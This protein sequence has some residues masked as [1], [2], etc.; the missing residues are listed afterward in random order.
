[1]SRRNTVRVVS[2][3]L[4]VTLSFALFSFKTKLERDNY[5]LQAQNRYS[6]TLNE[7]CASTDSMALLLQ[8]MQYFTSPEK[9]SSA[10]ATLLTQAEI[11][12]NA[13]AQLP[14]GNE[15]DALNKYLSQIGNYAAALAKKAGKTG[16]LTAEEA[17][18]IEYL[19]GVSQAVAQTLNNSRNS[20]DNSEYWYK[21]VQNSLKNQIDTTALEQSF[22]DLQE[23]FKD[24]PTLIYDGPYSEHILTKSPE[25]LANAKAVTKVEAEKTALEW[26]D[27][28]AG[29]LDFAGE[30]AGSIATYDFYGA[31][32]SVSVTQKGGYVLYLSRQFKINEIKIDSGAALKN[33]AEFLRKNNMLNMEKTYY[34]ESDGVCTVNYAYRQGGTLCYTDLVKVGVSME[35][36][37]I[38]F[39]EAGGF[40]SNHKSRS[41]STPKYGISAAQKAV[42]NKLKVKSNQQALIPSTAQEEKLCYEFLC[43]N[44]DCQ[45]I[46]V[47]INANNLEEEEILFL[48]KSDGGTLVK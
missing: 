7:L 1:M 24:Y 44:S 45:E 19:S 22:S 18:N 48:L 38:V 14:I 17:E 16:R 43:Q 3:S 29:D 20:F 36:G 33:A 21:T 41:L 12:K 5:A 6:H 32:I 30:T 35:S 34:F 26:T 2:F 15:I 42:S 10:A 25:M 27:S 11:S 37:E 4:A 8:K 31:G 9:L 28:E 39:Y 40:I 47:Y 13:L 23:D 46:L